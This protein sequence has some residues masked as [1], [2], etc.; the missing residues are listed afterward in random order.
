MN[1]FFC[2]A[3][4]T[5]GLP[6]THS[7]EKRDKYGQV[8]FLDYEHIAATKQDK[9]GIILPDKSH[10]LIY[11]E[12]SNITRNFS[13]SLYHLRIDNFYSLLKI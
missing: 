4:R 8:S 12:Q 6:A 13:S 5:R 11:N 1:L 9:T 10:I 3:R 2:K 7:T